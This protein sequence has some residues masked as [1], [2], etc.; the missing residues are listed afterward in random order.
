MKKTNKLL[1]IFIVALVLSSCGTVKNSGKYHE[2]KVMNTAD[3][4][5]DCLLYTS[6]AADE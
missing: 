3:I 2:K 6:D 5:T 1:S 4:T